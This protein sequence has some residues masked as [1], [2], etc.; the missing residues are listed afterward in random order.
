MTGEDVSAIERATMIAAKYRKEVIAL[1][2]QVLCDS[3]R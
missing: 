1:F 3:S 2:I